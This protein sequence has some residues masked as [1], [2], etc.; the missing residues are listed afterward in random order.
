MGKLGT[1][2]VFLGFTVR[3]SF[4][5]FGLKKAVVIHHPGA[6]CPVQREGCYCP[7]RRSSPTEASNICI[8]IICL[9]N[10]VNFTRKLDCK[11]R[12]N[13]LKLTQL[14]EYKSCSVLFGSN[15]LLMAE[16][17]RAWMGDCNF[18]QSLEMWASCLRVKSWHVL[19][20]HSTSMGSD[21]FIPSSQ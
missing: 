4:L 12:D 13:W 6:T 17:E 16:K 3:I 1:V 7:K 10:L 20:L 2:G 14:Q 9:A 18:R 19:F 15:V 5:Q 21:A 11:I 8:V